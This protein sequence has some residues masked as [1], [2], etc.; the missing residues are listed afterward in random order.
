ML[1]PCGLYYK[2]MTI[3]NDDSRVITKLETSLADDA[4]VVIYDCIMFIAQTTSEFKLTK[5]LI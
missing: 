2:P 4:R 5:Y 3:V 1:A